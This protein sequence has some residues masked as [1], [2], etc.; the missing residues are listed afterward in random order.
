MT[1]NLYQRFV[2]AATDPDKVFIVTPGRSSISFRDAF[3]AAARFAHVLAAHGVR[4]GDRVAAQVGKSP[5]A[6]FLYLAC[7]RTGAVYLPLNT[8]YTASEL[9]LFRRRRRAARLR[10]RCEGQGENRRRF[11]GHGASH[12]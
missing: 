9:S 10:L 5:E 6:L 12:A 2:H 11:A 1:D 7:L 3:G 8:D 4:P